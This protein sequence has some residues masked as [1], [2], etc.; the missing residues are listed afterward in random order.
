[1][2][3]SSSS[4]VKSSIN[5]INRMINESYLSATNSCKVDVNLPQTISFQCNVSD[6]TA[7]LL[8]AAESQCRGQYTDLSAEKVNEM[9]P[10]DSFKSC[11][12]DGVSQDMVVSSRTNCQIDNDMIN[13]MKADLQQKLENAA[14]SESDAFGEALVNA[15]RVL[16]PDGSDEE[17]IE[18][19]TEII[20]EIVSKI[21]VDLVNKIQARYNS[22]Q[23]LEFEGQSY[24]LK[25]VSQSL[26]MDI[27]TQALSQS[28]TLSD[29]EGSLSNDASNKSEKKQ[30]GLTDIFEEFTDLFGSPMFIIGIVMVVVF[31]F[32]IILVS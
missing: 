9:C 25:N 23:T 18:T 32:L 19:K 12:I 16:N 13:T 10:P 28:T 22:A 17:N 4:S 2:G 24:S 1:M 5:A 14:N 26:T 30:K 3:N 31:M 11:V 7:Q 21:T 15:T 29:L 20:N 8:I 27:V 6:E